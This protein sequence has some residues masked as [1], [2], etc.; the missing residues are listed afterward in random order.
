MD[1]KLLYDSFSAFG[2]RDAQSDARSGHGPHESFGFVA[3]DTFEAADMA[4]ECMNQQFLC[5]FPSRCSTPSSATRRASA[6]APRQSACWPPT[7][8]PPA[9]PH[10][11][12]HVRGQDERRG[13]NGGRGGAT[14]RSR[15][16]PWEAEERCHRRRHRQ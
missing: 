7:R 5:N 8:L 9:S 13:W 11:A 6:T 1:E 12:H 15:L 3:F 16:R 14:S 10:A 4:I 2:D